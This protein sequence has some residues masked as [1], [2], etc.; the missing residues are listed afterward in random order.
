MPHPY[1]RPIRLLRWCF[2]ILPLLALSSCVLIVTTSPTAIS[3]ATVVFVAIDDDGGAVSSLHI[4]VAD[5]FGDWREA[6]LTGRDG[7]FRCDVRAGVSRVR[8][9][10]AL[11]SGVMLTRSEQWPR[12]LDVQ[13]GS[14]VRL[15]IRVRAG[16]K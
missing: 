13:S 5:V 10:V 1:R 6:G 12:E 3:G 9:T 16:T 8:A 11:P 4:T 14:T 2:A 15:E 7:A